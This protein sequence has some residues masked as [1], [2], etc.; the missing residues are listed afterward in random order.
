MVVADPCGLAEIVVYT[1]AAADNHQSAHNV[2]KTAAEQALQ[3]ILAELQKG[4]ERI[5]VGNGN[6][7]H[8]HTKG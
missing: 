3:E 2:D 5:T 7:E 4:G 8:Q 1:H 6:Q